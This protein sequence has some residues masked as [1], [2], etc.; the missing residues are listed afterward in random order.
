MMNAPMVLA[1]GR[2]L[3]TRTPQHA[4]IVAR[5]KF[6]IFVR[7]QA[8]PRNATNMKPAVILK[9]HRHSAGVNCAPEDQILD[10]NG[11]LPSFPGWGTS[12]F[13]LCLLKGSS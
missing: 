3:Y 12:W 8:F 13:F 9:R 2:P 5:V 11:E 6:G 1:V 10:R 7:P 4:A